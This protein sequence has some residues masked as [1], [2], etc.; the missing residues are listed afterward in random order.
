[1][2]GALAPA[3]PL[4]ITLTMAEPCWPGTTGAIRSS[5]V[6]PQVKSADSSSLLSRDSNRGLILEADVCLRVLSLLLETLL[7]VCGLARHPDRWNM[8]PPARACCVAWR[9]K[10]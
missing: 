5:E 10:D 6:I 8:F 1:M 9:F 4:L 2:R 3:L 7:R